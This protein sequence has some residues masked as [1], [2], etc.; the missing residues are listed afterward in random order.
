M[1]RRSEQV[2]EVIRRAVQEVLTE[3]LADPRLSGLMLTVTSVTIDSD[4]TLALAHV[5]VLPHDKESRALPALRAA[6]RHIRRRVA[7]RIEMHKMPELQFRLDEGLKKQAG[8]LQ[9]LDMA[10]REREER[11]RRGDAESAETEKN[12]D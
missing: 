4:L 3:G 10:R 5:S 11:T 9:A 2:A 8:V 1:S 7:D 6:A 12:E